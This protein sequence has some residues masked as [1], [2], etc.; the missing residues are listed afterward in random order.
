MPGSTNM[1]ICGNQPFNKNKTL[2][3]NK[4]DRIVPKFHAEEWKKV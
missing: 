1:K 2:V 4:R 3:Q